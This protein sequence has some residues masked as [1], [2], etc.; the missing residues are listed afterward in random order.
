MSGRASSSWRSP[1]R[2]RLTA[3]KMRWRMLR[4]WTGQLLTLH[5]MGSRRSLSSPRTL[6]QP[7]E[8]SSQSRLLR[9]QAASRVQLGPA[10]SRAW[11]PQ[12]LS[13]VWHQGRIAVLCSCI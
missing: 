10:A 3:L 6:G 11:T 4:R 9:P 8:A 5:Q 13:T 12:A 2:S 1:V 7:A